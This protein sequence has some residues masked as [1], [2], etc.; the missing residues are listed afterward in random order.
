MNK[1]R[2]TTS[3]GD[4]LSICRDDRDE[5]TELW[6]LTSTKHIKLPRYYRSQRG[7]KLAAGRLTGEILVWEPWEA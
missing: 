1:I 6:C 7:A 4:V 3:N 2:A 5:L